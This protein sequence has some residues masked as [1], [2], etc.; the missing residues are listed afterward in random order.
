MIHPYE[1]FYLPLIQKKVAVIYTLAV[2][3][4]ELDIDE[5]SSLFARSEISFALYSCDPKYALGKSANELLGIILNKEPIKEEIRE[6]ASS[7]YWVGHVLSYASWYFNMPYKD[8]L[9]RFSSSEIENH[10]SLY[11]EMDILKVMELFARRLQKESS[12]KKK[13]K[14][15]GYSQNDLALLSGVP[16]R[17]IRAYEQGNVDIAKGEAETLYALSKALGC[18]IEDLI[19]N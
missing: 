4:L 7:A 3:N 14:E 5:F 11:H 17:T 9:E 13:R 6:D 16:I 8:I 15:L 12:L 18:S 1:E 2:D 10:Y 19:S